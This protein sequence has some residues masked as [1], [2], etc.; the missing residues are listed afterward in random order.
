MK[1][2]SNKN[3]QRETPISRA[4]REERMR[5]AINVAIA[6]SYEKARRALKV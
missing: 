2:N 3:P 1:I 6:P 4:I 5:T